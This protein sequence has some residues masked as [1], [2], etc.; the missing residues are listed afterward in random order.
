[1][2]TFFHGGP[3]E[4][5]PD[6][7][8]TLYLM[9]PGYVGYAS[10]GPPHAN[11]L[12]LNHS[13][14]SAS[15]QSAHQQQLLGVPLHGQVSAA[16]STVDHARPISIALPNDISTVQY[17]QWTAEAAAR[18]PGG[19]SLSLSPQ[20]QS[21]GA[22]RSNEIPTLH[23]ILSG[24][25]FL[26]AAQQLLDEVVNVGK[27]AKELCPKH[28]KNSTRAAKEADDSGG[29]AAGSKPKPELTAAE[30]Q[31][32][33]L[34]KAK[35][36]T[37]LDEVEQTYRRY[38]QQMQ[39][40]VS[41]FEAIAGF[42]SARTYTF[43]ALQTISKQFRSLKDAIIGQIRAT[44]RS[45]GE[46][47]GQIG[48]EKGEGSSRLRFVDQQLRQQRALHHL[49][50][51]QNNAW[52]PQ[53][54]LPE[55]AVSVL[56]AW[57]FEHFLHP[58]PKDADK[59]MLAKQTGLTRSQV[60]NWFINARVR[61]WKPMVEEMYLEETKGQELPRSE[62]DDA[63]SKRELN[64]DSVNVSGDRRLSEDDQKLHSAMIPSSE[65]S[66]IIRMKETAL[67]D[68]KYKK[69]RTEEGSISM[70]G[71]PHGLQIA[72]EFMPEATNRDPFNVNRRSLEDGGYSFG[73]FPMGDLGRFDPGQ[74]TPRFSGNAVSLTLGLPH[75]EN[76]PLSAA[77]PSFMSAETGEFC[78]IRNAPARATPSNAFDNINI[79]NRKGFAASLLPDFVA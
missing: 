19:L 42:G 68:A 70:N 24:S 28:Q 47:E 71:I 67:Y 79:P 26:K 10:D 20:H 30:R 38:Q 22:Y 51:V 58:Y 55:R 36:N 78:N 44:S 4:I 39:I 75:C 54:G 27:A 59:L 35:L 15:Q 16:S 1:M 2:A 17:N 46:D 33:Q 50:M 32:Q 48:G 77:Q 21:Y 66:G 65:L 29:E 43:L 52:R 72:L 41:S 13:A 3:Q 63:V 69:A 5:Q 76:L 60:S 12:L 45:L 56:R 64:E 57:L 73:S 11:M 34:K 40:V 31:E 61:L 25:K 49:G 37:M 18:Q 62:G 9:N 8:Q 7:L 23:G 53:R 14:V 74:F 6:G